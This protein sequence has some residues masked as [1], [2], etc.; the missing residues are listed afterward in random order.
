MDTDY[1]HFDARAYLKER[2]PGNEF[3]VYNKRIHTQWG[4]TVIHNFYKE[5]HSQW[6]NSSASLLEF[7]AGPYIHTLI[8]A[9]P[10]V[11]QIYHSDYLKQCRNEALLWKNDDPKA[12]D[13]SPY[14]RFIVTT[15]ET[16]S[17]MDAV[18]E[19]QELLRRKLK[20]SLFLDMRSSNPLPSHP[21]LFDIIYTGFCIESIASSLKEYRSTI[22]KVFDL[23]NPNGFLLMLS[24]LGC[25]YVVFSE[26]HKVSYLSNL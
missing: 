4:L 25:S 21:G 12:Y 22:K 3:Q 9:A 14:F 23:L 18:I 5:F 26:R 19:R 10:Y 7:G 2:C 11:D 1:Q 17:G 8:S 15:L 16:Q 6:D 24:S 13:W 20:D